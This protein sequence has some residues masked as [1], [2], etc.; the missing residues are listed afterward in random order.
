MIAKNILQ[1]KTRKRHDSNIKILQD[2]IQE[3]RDSKQ[4]TGLEQCQAR[5]EKKLNFHFNALMTAI[6][7]A[8]CILR[9][10]V[11]KN[12]S[13]SSLIGDLKLKFKK[14]KYALSNILNLWFRP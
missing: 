4:Y 1:N 6:N 2:K 14:Q 3:F 9:N 11:D 8:K 5:S 12:I 13:I 10:D 7:M